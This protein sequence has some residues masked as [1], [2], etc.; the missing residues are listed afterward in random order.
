MLFEGLPEKE[1]DYWHRHNCEVLSGPDADS[2]SDGVR[3]ACDALRTSRPPLEIR[4]NLSYVV[5]AV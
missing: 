3:N 2:R 5:S 4:D 1:K